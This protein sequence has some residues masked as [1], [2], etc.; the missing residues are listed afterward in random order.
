M[1]IFAL[2][3]STMLFVACG[4]GEKEKVE[5]VKT[6]ATSGAEN[7]SS[8]DIGGATTDGQD[9]VETVSGEEAPAEGEMMEKKEMPEEAPEATP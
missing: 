8:G 7:V 2:I 6:S 5:E 1:K 4:G 3:F 9:I